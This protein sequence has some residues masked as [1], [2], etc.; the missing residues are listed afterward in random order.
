[1]ITVG[2][3]PLEADQCKSTIR[4]AAKLVCRK[5]LMQSRNKKRKMDF[6]KMD[7]QRIANANLAHY[8]ITRKP[9]GFHQVGASIKLL[10]DPGF[11][12]CGPSTKAG[13]AYKFMFCRNLYTI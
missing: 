4:K 6:R 3:P 13:F 9:T 2:S 5:R 11:E 7:R 12:T 10:D 8:Q 1:M